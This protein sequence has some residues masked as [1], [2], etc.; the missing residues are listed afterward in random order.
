MTYEEIVVDNDFIHE[1][2][3]YREIEEGIG[4]V[5]GSSI[6][7]S[8]FAEKMVGMKPYSWQVYVMELFRRSIKERA[9]K[10]E[11][12][13]SNM[14]SEEDDGYIKIDVDGK[15]FIII[16]SRQIGKSTLIAIM[17]LWVTLF[18]KVSSTIFENTSIIIVSASDQQAK[19][20][21][22]D[23]N[24]LLIIG[25][26][27]MATYV[28]DDEPIFGKHY[29]TDLLSKDDPN[30]TE[31]ITFTKHDED[32]HGKFLLAGSKH[33]STIKS[34]PPTSKVL[35]E[36]ASV[37]WIDEAAFSDKV[38]DLF[39]FDYLYP[40]GNATNAIRGY[41]STPWATSGFFYRMVDPDGVYN[42]KNVIVACFT[43]DAIRIENKNQYD[44]SMKIINQLNADGKMHEVQ[45]AYYCR[46]VKGEKSFFDPEKVNEVFD[47]DM[48]SLTSFKGDC[49]VGI[50]FGGQKSSKTVVTISMLDD[51][52]HIHRLYEHHYGVQ[53]DLT[54][55]DDIKDLMKDFNIQRVVVDS[56]PEGDFLIRRMEEEL[57]WDVTHFVFRTDKVKKFNAF[58]SMVNKGKVHS[59][60]DEDLKTEMGALE[61]TTGGQRSLIAH[62]PGYSDDYID[63]FIISCYNFIQDDTDRVGFYDWGMDNA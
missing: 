61:H 54:L 11:L 58:R 18:N 8:F 43:I 62:A 55:L 1:M 23:V 10:L 49:D 63:S 13:I 56:C 24:R 19:K 46:F 21:L 34:Y 52:G 27:K 42:N 47:N 39:V 29:F 17:S 57:H 14:G 5:Q 2:E 33:G 4:L 37:I 25:D 44:N 15:E 30:N 22:R 16:T 41:T 3:V 28:D 7:P 38:T 32:K 48:Q 26:A 35:G 60:Q 12:D 51:D 20:L 40:V 50:D 45:R 6:N 53:Q 31:M 59:Y 36:S 9:I